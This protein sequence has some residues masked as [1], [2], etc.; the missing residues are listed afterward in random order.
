MDDR[1]SYVSMLDIEN[2]LAILGKISI[3]AGLT[4]SQLYTLF[5]LLHKV[6]YKVNEVIFEQGDQ[7]SHIYIVKKGCVKLV[8]WKDQVPYELVLVAL[9]VGL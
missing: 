5:R 8:V 6:T 1:K 7:P 4:D 3:L 9:H 2:V